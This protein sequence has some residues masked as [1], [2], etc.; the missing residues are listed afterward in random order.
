MPLLD[1][2]LVFS[3]RFRR[4]MLALGPMAVSSDLGIWRTQKCFEEKKLNSVR[5]DFGRPFLC[6]RHGAHML[7]LL[8]DLFCH[9]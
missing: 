9:Q 2:Q 7:H 8:S 4:F 6:V 3:I 5:T 1:V